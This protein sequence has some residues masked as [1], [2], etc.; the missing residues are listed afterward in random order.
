MTLGGSI[1]FLAAR[2]M[3]TKNGANFKCPYSDDVSAIEVKKNRNF[4]YRFLK[5]PLVKFHKIWLR[6]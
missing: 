6:C 3:G 1:G 5:F 2:R 4:P